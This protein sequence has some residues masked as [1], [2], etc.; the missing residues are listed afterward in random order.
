MMA[1]PPREEPPLRDPAALVVARLLLL[2]A[3]TLAP[4]ALAADSIRCDGGIVSVGD[5]RLD[6]LGKCGLPALQ[7]A[8]PVLWSPTVD[9]TLLIER[10]TYNFGPDRFIQIVSLQGGKVIAIE[11]GGY[12][13]AL[14]EPSPEAP[15]RAVA[16]PRARC[17]HDAFRVGDSTFEVLAR[18]GE[19]FSRELRP[20]RARAE[21]WTYDFGQRTLVRYLE[22][23]GG[24]L[25]RI[26]TG[27]YG[28]SR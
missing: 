28:Y 20:G 14:P 26:R 27:S 17:A 15:G 11:R 24:R 16:I 3:V 1:A 6:L 2:G 12:G 13:F 5:S 10:W 19:P 7:E 25:V 22:F 8:E 23:E 4:P 21:V 9:L 18:C